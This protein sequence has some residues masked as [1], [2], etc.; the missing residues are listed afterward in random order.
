[1]KLFF[2]LSLLSL[3]I[4]ILLYVNSPRLKSNSSNNTFQTS[5]LKSHVYNLSHTIGERN[6]RKPLELEKA[7]N[8]IK[9]HLNKLNLNVQSQKYQI[10]T[11]KDFL[12]IPMR[13]SPFYVE[14][15]YV[16][17]NPKSTL[18][19]LVVGA[20]YDTFLGTPGADDNASS[21]AVL[22][23]IIQKLSLKPSLK[24][25]IHFVFFTLEEP[26]FFQ[27]NEMGSYQF[28]KMLKSNNTNLLGMISLDC[29]GYFSDNQRFPFPLNLFY[30]RKGDFI[31]LIASLN[32]FSFYKLVVNNTFQNNRLKI[33]NFSLPSILPGVTYS[34]HWS[35]EE[36]SYSGVL[37]TDS[38]FYR[39]DHY[40][41]NSD[42]FQTLNYK[43]LN[44]FTNILSNLIQVL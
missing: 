40:H 38:A 5:E 9:V 16:T 22:L 14:N 7:A 28:A 23:Q 25:P 34:D 24:R 33:L 44:E 11:N 15:I 13:K 1:L 37:F 21:V 41:E 2:Y 18:P 29:L 39:S 3:F 42:T 27:T 17:I 32:S 35:F 8:Y 30:K 26:P 10:K 4:C 20:H 43:K 6:I 12:P 36:F 31:S 19:H